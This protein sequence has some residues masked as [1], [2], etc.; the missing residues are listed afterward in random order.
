MR[1]YNWIG[2]ITLVAVLAAGC[3]SAPKAGSGLPGDPGPQGKPEAPFL[4][5]P[6]VVAEL[7]AS[8]AW[9]LLSDTAKWGEWCPKAMSVT[10]ALPLT[11]GAEVAWAWG[12]KSVH[13][14]V[15][16]LSDG[17]ALWLQGAAS[18]DKV[19]L[20]WNLQAL[21]PDR[22]SVSLK[23]ALRPGSKEELIAAAMAETTDWIVAFKA[24]L[25]KL[26]ASK[27]KPSKKGKK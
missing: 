1:L 6:D 17:Q 10:A 26:A 16:K 12:G 20:R 4:V 24:E 5:G 23:A 13:A 11:P 21:A 25:D 2:G 9:G 18:G 3:S 7:S 22:V 15:A 27:P 8:E 14:T 19:V